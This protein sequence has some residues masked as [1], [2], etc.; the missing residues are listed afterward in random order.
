MVSQMCPPFDVTQTLPVLLTVNYTYITER[1]DRLRPL[2]MRLWR[3]LELSRIHLRNDTESCVVV[4]YL[5]N[6]FASHLHQV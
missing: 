2:D 6:I 3:F 5:G 4:L 1:P